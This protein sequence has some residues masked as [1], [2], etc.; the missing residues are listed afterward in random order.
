MK[1]LVTGFAPFDGDDSNPAQEALRR[2]PPRLGGL[3]LTVRILPTAF[4]QALDALAD[5]LATT[6]PAA[7][8][9]PTTAAP[10]A[11]VPPVTTTLDPSNATIA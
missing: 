6:A 2:L 11:P 5:A 7:R 1:A 8:S 4:G 3:E 10:N 9:A